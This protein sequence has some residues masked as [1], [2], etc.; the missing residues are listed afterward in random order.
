MRDDVSRLVLEGFEVRRD[1]EVGG[2]L[3]LEVESVAGASCCPDSGRSSVDVKDRPVVRVRDLPIAGRLTHRVWRKP[4]YRCR[5]CGRRSTTSISCAALTPRT[6]RSG[7][8]ASPR[9][10]RGPTA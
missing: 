7:A 1:V 8:G 3:D 5:G 9:P 10:A 6:T 4:R 2:R